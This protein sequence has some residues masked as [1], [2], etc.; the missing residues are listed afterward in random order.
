LYRLQN[1]Q[2][3]H[4][5]Q[6]AIA[7]AACVNSSSAQLQD[8]LQTKLALHTVHAFAVLLHANLRDMSSFSSLRQY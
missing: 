2:E 4:V 6:V 3:E 7:I 8:A 5:G 1:P